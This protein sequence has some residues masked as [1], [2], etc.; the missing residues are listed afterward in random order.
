VQSSRQANKL[1]KIAIQTNTN[2]DWKSYKS[3]RNQITRLKKQ[4][5]LQ[6][7]NNAINNNQNKTKLAW[8]FLNK[9]IGKNKSSS[10]IDKIIVSGKEV[11]DNQDIANVMSLHYSTCANSIDTEEIIDV[12]DQESDCEAELAGFMVTEEDALS[13]IDYLK[14]NKPVGSDRIPAKFYKLCSNDLVPILTYMFNE[15]IRVGEMPGI[16]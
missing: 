11:T 10:T 16:L 3:Q 9:E 6:S 5:K 2:E 8:S 14:T 13:A 15:C 1:K 12:S 7:L 4:L